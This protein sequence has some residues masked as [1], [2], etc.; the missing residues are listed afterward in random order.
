M[1][2][3]ATSPTALLNRD[4]FLLW[5]GQVVS[6]LGSQAFAIAMA[7]WTLE[8]TGSATLMG[9][10][11]TASRVGTVV[12]GPLAGAFADS[13]Q[14]LRIIVVC[15]VARG[16]VTC[17]LALA[18]WFLPPEMLVV[19]LFLVALGNG[20]FTALFNPAVASLTPEL[21]PEHRL[22]A[23]NSLQHLSMQTGALIGQ[24]L[25]GVLYRLLGAPVLLLVDGV[26][27]LFSG[28]SESL[29]RRRADGVPDRPGQGAWP[30]LWRATIE[31]VRYLSRRPG[32]RIFFL[33]AAV[34]NLVAMPVIALLPIY[35]TDY[36]HAKPDWYGFLLAAL[37]AGMVCGYGV[38]AVLRVRS[39]NHARLI[40][41]MFAGVALGLSVLGQVETAGV[42]LLI[43]VALGLTSGIINT[44]E[45]T[46]LQRTTPR[47][48][49]GRVMGLMYTTSEALTPLGMVAGGLAADLTGRNLPLIYGVCGA[50]AT[51]AVLAVGGNRAS[52]EYLT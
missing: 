31:G 8:V 5:Q 2:V 49:R 17:G 26:T 50:I 6:R 7:F 43:M 16:L 44:L 3:P 18:F 38:T 15:D 9:V 28:A 4:F 40:I 32:L 35:V 36:L 29:I 13:H 33:S 52:L 45:L 37:S 51:M 30:E 48:F 19:P 21:V 41:A 46:L 47:E 1:A 14:L 10:M 27:F 22:A 42:A 20:V 34:M 23:A 12:F 11:M 25:A 39:K 24:G